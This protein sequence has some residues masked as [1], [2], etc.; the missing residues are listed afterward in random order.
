MNT[1]LLGQM[2]DKLASK[3]AE[4]VPLFYKRFF[5]QYPDYE[6]LFSES[7]E[8]EMGKML[9]MVTRMARVAGE[10]EVSH[11]QLVKLGEKHSHFKVTRGDLENFKMVYL[12]VLNGRATQHL[13]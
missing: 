11:P 9:E 2:W 7:R 13:L 1:E 3:Q 10:S 6:L 8:R 4:F 12:Q 5:E